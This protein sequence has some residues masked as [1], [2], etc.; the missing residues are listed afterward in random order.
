MSEKSAPYLHLVRQTPSGDSD[1][2]HDQSQQGEQDEPSSQQG[3]SDDQPSSEQPSSAPAA[4]NQPLQQAIMYAA[5]SWVALCAERT[6]CAV[7]IQP[8]ARRLYEVSVHYS[9]AVT[10][11]EA[12]GEGI[13]LRIALAIELGV[14]LRTRVEPVRP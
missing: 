12:H 7:D 9:D 8:I 11:G 14:V 4:L 1:Q 3:A 5:V 2:S 6:V 10:G 13:I